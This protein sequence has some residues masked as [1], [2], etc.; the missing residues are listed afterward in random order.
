MN[1]SLLVISLCVFA[2]H[3]AAMTATVAPVSGPAPSSAPGVTVSGSNASTAATANTPVQAAPSGGVASSRAAAPSASSVT[4]P[5][6]LLSAPDV[7]E[8]AAVAPSGKSAGVRDKALI[9][10]ATKVAPAST[11][12]GRAW[13]AAAAGGASMRR[14][15]LEAFNSSAATLQV[16]GQKLNFNPQRV[17][18]F[19]RSGKAGSIYTLKSGA[20]VRFTMDP[21]DRAQRRV[22]V[23]YVE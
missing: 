12:A 13:A 4:K 3:C 6:G 14:G 5:A 16:Y 20:K 23:I 11:A 10:P 19:D 18:V 9:L 2:A 1:R 21:A 7:P 15:T 17:K 22:A 8:K